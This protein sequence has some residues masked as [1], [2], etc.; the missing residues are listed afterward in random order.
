MECKSNLSAGPAILTAFATLCCASPALHAQES[1]ESVAGAPEV[2]SSRDVVAYDAEFFALYHPVTALEM[3]RRL[4]GFQLDDG[5]DKRGF[6]AA[7]GNVLI[8]DRYPSAKQDTASRI[9]ERIPASQ[10][11]RIDLIRGRVRGIDLRSQSSVISVIL[12]EDI[13]ATVRW[14]LAVRKTF[15]LSP[16]TVRGSASLSDTWKSIEY[17]VGLVYRRFRSSESG[18]EDIFDP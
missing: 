16:L 6:G 15:D 4:P 9:L 11:E 1:G 3:V 2:E 14:D 10:V 7:S 13:S 17:N 8:N 5:E 18:V 12:R